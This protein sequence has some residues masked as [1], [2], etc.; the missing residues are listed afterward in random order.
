MSRVRPILAR[1]G[2]AFLVEQQ[3][4]LTLVDTGAPGSLRRIRRALAR[5]GRR[6][7]DIRQIVLTHCHGDHAGEA[8]RIRELTGAPVIAGARDVG[9]IEGRDP[10]PGP[11]AAWG[12]LLY[13]W[14][15]GYPRFGVDRAVS[16]RT[17]I[18]GGLVVIPAPGHTA[19]HLAVFA[20]DA[21]ALFLGDAVWQI[22]PLRAS[23]RAFTWD[24]ARNLESIRELADLPSD[25]LFLGH[26]PPVRR[27]GRDRLRSLAE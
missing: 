23:W 20:P 4:I 5:I 21:R 24:P 3:G 16:E 15:R 13:G 11:K 7:E 25:A 26:G 1:A 19:G 27:A 14:L 8:G 6:P 22:G 10:Y 9:V 12:R 17:E 2:R 18:D